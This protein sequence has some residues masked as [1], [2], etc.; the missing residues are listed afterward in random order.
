MLLDKPEPDG[1]PVVASVKGLIDAFRKRWQTWQAQREYFSLATFCRNKQVPTNSD[2]VHIA[3]MAKR[4]REWD[5]ETGR[6]N[7]AIDRRRTDRLIKAAKKAGD[8]SAADSALRALVEAEAW[9]NL[10]E[11][12][13]REPYSTEGERYET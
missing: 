11:Q 4:R 6:R 5:V 2:S 13:L 7:L 1:L 3:R 9:Q 8:F 12:E 10:A